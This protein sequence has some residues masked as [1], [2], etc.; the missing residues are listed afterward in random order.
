MSGA[1]DFSA[2]WWIQAL[3]NEVE[4]PKERQ[5]GHEVFGREISYDTAADPA[6]PTRLLKPKRSNRCHEQHR[7]AQPV[8]IALAPGAYAL[9]FRLRK[10]QRPPRKL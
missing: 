6:G 7:S 10:L 5:I 9:H 3:L 2:I 4:V 8:H 1:R